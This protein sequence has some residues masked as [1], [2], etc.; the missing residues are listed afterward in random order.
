MFWNR[1]PRYE[2]VEPDSMEVLDRGWRRIVSEIGIEFGLPESLDAF[3]AAGQKVDGTVVHLDPEFVVE[4]LAKAPPEFDVQARNPERSLHLGGDAMAFAAVYGPPFVR[5]GD[6]RRDATYDDFQ[7]LVKLAQRYDEIDTPG[8]VICE[9]N[10]LPLD[11]RHLDMTFALQTLSDKPFFGSVTSGP[12]AED[13]I[14][15]AEILF[16]GRD[17]IEQTPVMFAIVNVNSPLRYDERMLAALHAYA[18]AA[19]PVIVTPFLLMGAM[20]P[21]TIP[22]TIAQQSAEAFAGIALIQLLRPGAP[23]LLGSFLSTTNMQS[24]APNFGGPES[25]LGLACTGQIARRYG[26]PWRAGGGALTSSQTADAQAAYEGMNTMLPAFMAGANLVM[27]T[28]GWLESG[29]VSGYEKFIVDVEILRTLEHEFTPITIDEASLAF[30]AHL[31][32][33]HGGHFLGAAHTLERFRECFY[34]PFL[35][36]SENFERWTRNGGRD[37]A[38]RAAGIWRAELEA[39]EPP[40]LDDGVRE[41]LEQYVTRRRRELGD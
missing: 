36:S 37:A 4:Q 33:G 22:A 27:H 29:L 6:V 16:G 9:P 18:A 32:V 21:V 40:P 25:A 15:M 23:V 19:Q 31:E 20:S 28:A 30:D 3:R 35:S 17:A 38:E 13:S 39:Y 26:L 2:I 1:M 5:E 7:R 11:S 24:G 34:R 12:N 14:R 8:G 41:Q 10:D